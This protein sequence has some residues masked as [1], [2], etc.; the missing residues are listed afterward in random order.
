[1]MD[2]ATVLSVLSVLLESSIAPAPGDTAVSDGELA[3]DIEP[4]ANP[5][6]APDTAAGRGSDQTSAD[7]EPEPSVESPGTIPEDPQLTAPANKRIPPAFEPNITTLDPQVGVDPLHSGLPQPGLRPEVTIPTLDV[8][9][10]TV[11]YESKDTFAKATL[12]PFALFLP[13]YHPF[14]SE[15]RISAFSNVGKS[16]FGGTFT[17]GYSSAGNRLSA[18]EV[19]DF[20]GIENDCRK[21]IKAKLDNRK[22]YWLGQLTPIINR[23]GGSVSEK[24]DVTDRAAEDLATWEWIKDGVAGPDLAKGSA[25]AEHLYELQDGGEDARTKCLGKKLVEK[26]MAEA[27]TNAWGVY[28]SLSTSGF[29]VVR[30]PDLQK[31]PVCTEMQNP[32]DDA[33]FEDGTY[34]EVAPNRLATATGMVN[35]AYFPIPRLGLWVSGSYTAARSKPKLSDVSGEFTFGGVIAGL[36]RI[37]K[38]RDD[39]YLPG[40]GIGASYDQTY[41]QNRRNQKTNVRTRCLTSVPFYPDGTD[42]SM[43]VAVKPSV[44]VDLRMSTKLQVR[45]A[46]PVTAIKLYD[47]VEDAEPS[48][49]IIHFLPTVSA[50]VATWG[51]RR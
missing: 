6:A 50:S 34:E 37:G 51:V 26:R 2:I 24:S 19:S 27:Y 20:P 49:W 29:A 41:C 4:T 21:E 25:V 43:R 13:K 9:S 3:P 18:L 10:A 23:H 48:S 39:G 15:L 11:K 38:P 12:A 1:M 8:L 46:L 17:G 28:G 40:I 16:T 31:T 7:P 33:C 42:I 36:V 5:T 32:D 30:G 14:W 47:L 45:V 35:F 44:F 22:Q